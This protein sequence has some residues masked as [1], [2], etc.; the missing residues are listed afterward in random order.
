MGSRPCRLC[1]P[2]RMGRS[3]RHEASRALW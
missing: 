1:R 3:R 2:S